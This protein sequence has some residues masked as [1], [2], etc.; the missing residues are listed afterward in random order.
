MRRFVVAFATFLVPAA[1]FAQEA[2]PRRVFVVHAGLHTI[3]SDTWPNLAADNIAAILQK[4]GI[5]AKDVVV[6]DNP[7][8]VASSKD[9][10]P[11]QTMAMFAESMLPSSKTS[12]ASYCRLHEAL[13]K[14]QVKAQDEVIWIGH[15]AGGQMGLT[16]AHLARRL[17][18]YPDLAQ[19][20]ASYPLNMVITL[21]SPI[22]SNPV[23]KEVK[24]RHYFS[25][26]DK[27]VR[28]ASIYGTLGLRLAG[29]SGRLFEFPPDLGPAGL[30]RVFQD[31]RHPYW[32][33]ER[34]VDC[35]LRE[36]QPA[37]QPLWRTTG[38][39]VDRASSLGR[40]LCRAVEETCQIVWEDVPVASPSK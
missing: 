32:D 28:W 1:L 18:D 27:V 10:F 7:F 11:K 24:V 19:K 29:H 38:L 20:T 12:A 14:I 9:M 22:G 23:P 35:I 8:P 5:A 39:G 2:S 13:K 21:G 40:L 15:S 30:V 6:L 4:R 17:T 26:E 16:M 34:I 36:F 3:L 37:P 25:P 33:E 31:I